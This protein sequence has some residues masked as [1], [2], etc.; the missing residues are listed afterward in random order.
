MSA[1][2]PPLPAADLDHVLAHTGRHWAGLRGAGLFITGGTG[3]F[4][5][6]LLESYVRANDALGLG[7]QAVVLSR[8]PGAFA[9][10]SPHLA[11]RADLRFV[12]GDLE[13]FA[14]PAGRFTHVIN[15]AAETTVWTKNASADG[16]LERIANGMG[17]VLDFVA[18]SRAE[19]FLHVGSGAMYGPPPADVTH[20]TEDHPC[21]TQPLPAGAVW[22]EGKRLEEALCQ[23]HAARHRYA[24][25]IARGF[26][27][28]GPHLPLDGNYAI[29]N[30]IGDAL[31]GGPIRVGGD[32]TPFR[33]YLYA[34]DL[35]IWLWTILAAGPSGRAYNVG[36]DD[37]R[38]IAAHARCV[39]AASGITA[40]VEVAQAADPSR[41]VS[42]YVPDIRRAR[43][44]LG[45]EVRIAEEEGIRRTLAWHSSRGDFSSPNGARR[46]S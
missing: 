36:S 3:F 23:A 2:L 21:Q 12:H 42:H 6:W 32:G 34:A 30:F 46:G 38:S 29:G 26:A 1:P 5:T 9:L 19:H 44:E 17:H 20:V 41:P 11:G 4:G 45:L 13:T 7:M 35:A 15:A 10:R 8:N 37:G 25:K 31:R 33:S 28:V 27:F 40:P 22:A 39:A 18:A 43:T 14:F 16:L 24:L